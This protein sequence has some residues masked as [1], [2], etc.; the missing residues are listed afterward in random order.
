MSAI[1]C[2]RCGRPHSVVTDVNG[3]PFLRM[4]SIP[5]P[6]WHRWTDGKVRDMKWVGPHKFAVDATVDRVEDIPP[7]PESEM[8]RYFRE[9]PNANTD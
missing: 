6:G 4:D 1:N 3:L 9:N 5:F 7:E 8:A 2:H